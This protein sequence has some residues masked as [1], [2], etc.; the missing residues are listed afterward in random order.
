[1][2]GAEIKQLRARLG[3]SQSEFSKVYGIPIGSLKNYEQGRRK[4]DKAGA[5]FF[6]LIRA[7]PVWVA[8]NLRD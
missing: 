1:M 4:P 8:I 7:D 3:M 6:R 5:N 2:T